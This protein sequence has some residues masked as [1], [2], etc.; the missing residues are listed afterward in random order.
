M[1]STWLNDTFSL[2]LSAK[3][4]NK[5]SESDDITFA[6]CYDSAFSNCFGS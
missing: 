5:N 3:T 6:V 1:H 4:W 2:I